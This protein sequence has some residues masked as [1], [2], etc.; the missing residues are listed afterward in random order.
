MQPNLSHLYENP[1]IWL[2]LCFGGILIITLAVFYAALRQAV[3]TKAGFILFG[4][5]TWLAVLLALA[6]SDFFLKT[7]AVP[8]RFFM[9]ILPPFTLILALFLTKNSR[10]FLDQLPIQTLTWLNTIRVPVELA[11]Y[12]LFIHHFIPEL[13]TFEGRNF[14]ILSGLTAPLAAYWAS[15]NTAAA[16]RKLLIWN[17]LALLL[18]INIVTHAV[19]AAPLPIQQLAFDQPNV[20]VLKFPFVGL[21]G[22]VV[23]LVLFGHLVS[24]RQLTKKHL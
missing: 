5:L 22:V 3:P 21:P 7:D 12:G 24:I 1:P 20:G 2:S 14:D 19:L 16:R 13:M 23:P 4:I 6:Q 15:Q 9:V 8:P 10:R 17:I 18:L 11:L